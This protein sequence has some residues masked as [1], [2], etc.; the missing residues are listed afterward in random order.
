MTTSQNNYADEIDNLED[1][2]LSDVP[3]IL[4]GSR[5]EQPRSEV[6]ASQ[7]VLTS[8]MIE[9]SGTRDIPSL[10]RLVPGFQ[11]ARVNG[12]TAVTYHG[13]SDIYSKRLQ[14]LIDG[15]SV[16]TPLFGGVDWSDLPIS[17]DDVERIEV[18]RGPN[19]VAYGANSFIGV[20]NIITIPPDLAQGNKLIVEGGKQGTGRMY[21]RYGNKDRKLS[22]RLSVE[23]KK[24]DYYRGVADD[25]RRQKINI[26]GIYNPDTVNTLDF[27]AGYITGDNSKGDGRVNDPFRREDITSYYQQLV[28]TRQVSNIE[29]V[30][31]N[32]SYNYHRVND[33]WDA[34]FPIPANLLITPPPAP[35]PGIIVPYQL[36]LSGF[37][38]RYNFEY[39]HTKRFSKQ[40]RAVWGAEVRLDQVSGIYDFG[41]FNTAD[42]IDNHLYRVFANTEWVANKDLNVNGGLLIEKN[43]ITNTNF[44]PRLALNYHL[45]PG[46]TFRSVA[47][48]AY[49]T[50]SA[51]EDRAN[52][53][54]DLGGIVL[55]PFDQNILFRGNQNLKPEKMTS[56]EL[57]YLFE[58]PESRSSIDVKLFYER[59]RDI[60]SDFEDKTATDADN[61][62]DP[63]YITGGKTDTWGIEAQAEYRPGRK[64]RLWVTYSY[65]Q[66]K[67]Q[68]IEKRLVNGTFVSRNLSGSVPR[69]TVSFLVSHKLE[70]DLSVSAG[71]YNVSSMKWVGGD[72]TGGY[73][74]MDVRISKRIKAGSLKGR[75]EVIIKDALKSYFDFDRAYKKEPVV[76]VSVSMEF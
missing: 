6:P 76:L 52:G 72:E 62:I 57:G 32:F 13:N 49:R 16:Y 67:G 64:T 61:E 30:K 46:H 59:I 55:P 69:H 12:V 44:S 11:V 58:M 43:D 27:S 34:F 5:L 53:V 4:T 40:F 54:I 28:W 18:V 60:I 29:E 14:V 63:A 33:V 36:S 35:I 47:S 73:N 24:N 48:I 56:Y 19:G 21:Y 31:L 26:R 7:T 1:E 38:K 51:F 39:Q 71:Y 66:L 50:P 2:F 42:T 15:R 45:K 41:Y 22:Y 70:Q 17:I 74:T 9:A 75:Y 20:I 3:V 8:E 37:E 68:Y 25:E 23:A 10:F 65:A